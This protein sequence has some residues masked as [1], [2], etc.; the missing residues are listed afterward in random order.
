MAEKEKNKGLGI[1]QTKG[2]FQ[3]R[4]VV[5]G[6]EKESFYK[7]T[8]TKTQ[9]PFRRVNFGLKTYKD[10]TVYVELTGMERDE[11][12]FSK[13]VTE[14]NQRKTDVQRVSWRD[15]FKFNKEGYRMIGVNVGVR[16]KLDEKGNEVND[17]KTLVEYDAIQEIADNLKDDQSV[18]VKGNIDYSHYSTNDGGVKRATKFI[19]TQISLCKDI[20]FDVEGFEPMADFTQTIVFDSIKQDE[21]DKSKFLVSAKIVN[22]NSVEEAEFVIVDKNLASIFKKNLNSYNSIKVWGNVV[23]EKDTTEEEV[24]DGWGSSNKM[25]KVNAP[26]ERKLIITGAD[27]NTLDKDTYSEEIIEQAITKV[28]ANDKAQQDFGDSNWGSVS[29]KSTDNDD[30]PW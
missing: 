7:D 3:F 23:V 17:K 11:V 13:T 14:N 19:P 24:S 15:R 29:G 5:T 16:K 27:P 9:K 30:E 1:P 18:F 10:A 26:T 6:T 28:K 12:F 22:Y 4:G 20:D 2:T 25:D 8:L 21:T